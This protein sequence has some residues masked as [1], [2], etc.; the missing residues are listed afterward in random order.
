MEF[1]NFDTS[2]EL[3]RYLHAAFVCL[4]GFRKKLSL[5]RRLVTDRCALDYVNETMMAIFRTFIHWFVNHPFSFLWIVDNSIV[6]RIKSRMNRA[7]ELRFYVCDCVPKW[8]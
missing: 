3:L 7:V 6:I 5:L 2:L 1:I 4:E 8:T